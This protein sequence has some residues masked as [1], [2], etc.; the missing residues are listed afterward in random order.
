[1]ALG[2]TKNV[3]MIWVVVYSTSMMKLVG[4]DG[5]IYYPKVTYQRRRRCTGII[6]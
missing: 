2:M 5:W 3:C 1:M 6:E 4:F